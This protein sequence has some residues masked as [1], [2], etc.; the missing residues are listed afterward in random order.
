MILNAESNLKKITDSDKIKTYDMERPY[1]SPGESSKTYDRE[2]LDNLK[3]SMLDAGTLEPIKIAICPN[4]PYKNSNSQYRVHGRILDGKHRYQIDANWP[5]EYFDFSEFQ[6]PF[7]EYNIQRQHFDL[8]KK[9]TKAETESLVK[10]ALDYHYQELH[11]PREQVCRRVAKYY[12]SR[13]IMKEVTVYRNCPDEYKDKSQQAI[14]KLRRN[15]R[16]T[17]DKKEIL[18]SQEEKKESTFANAQVLPKSDQ[19]KEMECV[20]TEPCQLNNA[21]KESVRDDTKVITEIDTKSGITEEIPPTNYKH[22][23]EKLHKNARHLVETINNLAA[24]KPLMIINHIKV[25]AHVDLKK[26][27]VIIEVEEIPQLGYHVSTH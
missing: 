25:Q 22:E 6:N 8:H 20:L 9:R 19:I 2:Q 16:R 5:R 14:A 27:M 24:S 7:L 1:V 21:Q 12:E 10:Q 15:V 23:Y 17:E 11:V 26:G 3:N 13:G 18:E 4:D